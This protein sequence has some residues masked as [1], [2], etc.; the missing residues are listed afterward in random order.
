MKYV[1]IVPGPTRL[2][3][4]INSF[5][6]NG[7]WIISNGNLTPPLSYTCVQQLSKIQEFDRFKTFAN[8]LLGRASKISDLISE[9]EGAADLAKKGPETSDGQRVTKSIPQSLQSIILFLFHRVKV[10]HKKSDLETVPRS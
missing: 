5:I 3:E 10:I 8:S 6:L 9:L 7:L 1:E 2:L 4:N